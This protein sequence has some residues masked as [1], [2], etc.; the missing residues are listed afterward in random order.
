MRVSKCHNTLTHFA[1]NVRYWDINSLE[2]KLVF[3]FVEVSPDGLTEVIVV[4]LLFIGRVWMTLV[5]VPLILE[6][7]LPPIPVV[8]GPLKIIVV[9]VTPFKDE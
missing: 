3:K 7:E 4:V 5:E 8:F 6:L 9:D 1:H 2:L